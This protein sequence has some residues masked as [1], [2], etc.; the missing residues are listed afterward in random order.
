ME[1]QLFTPSYCLFIYLFYIR[2]YNKSIA[3]INML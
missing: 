2:E 3:F 1:V